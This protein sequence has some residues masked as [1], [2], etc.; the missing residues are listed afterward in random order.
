MSGVIR[1]STL[2]PT[3]IVAITPATGIETARPL[4]PATSSPTR[5]VSRM[6]P[7]QQT[8]AP[9]AYK[10][11][12]GSTTP[13]HGWVSNTTPVAASPGH[14]MRAPPLPC[15]TATPSGPRN[16]NAL[17]V[18]SGIRST[19]AMN[20]MV[21]EAVTTPSITQAEKVVR[22]N[23]AARGRTMTSIRMPA[24]A[25]LSHAA[26]STPM[27]SI[28]VTA[29]A[30]PICTHSIDA[31]AMKAPVRAWLSVTTAL[32]GTVTVHVHVIFLDIPFGDHEQ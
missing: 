7:A 6:Y 16:S 31:I 28:K 22:V 29:I 27:R 17:A 30:R 10:T 18:P 4:K 13:C 15:A 26:P 2:G 21:I 3:T 11:P 9:S 8:A 24:Q 12:T 5:C 23:A 25:S 32:N 19:A 20:S 1:S 14:S